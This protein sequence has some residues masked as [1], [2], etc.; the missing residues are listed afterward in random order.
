MVESLKVLSKLKMEEQPRCK[1]KVNFNFSDEVKIKNII[2]WFRWNFSILSKEKKVLNTDTVKLRLPTN[3]VCEVG[4]NIRSHWKE[5]LDLIKNHYN[6]V[7]YIVSHHSY[8]GTV[9]NYL[10]KENKC[11]QHRLYRNHCIQCEDDGIK[12]YVKDLDTLNKYYNW[13]SFNR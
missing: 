13:C 12:F 3:K 11:F 5:V 10:D 1:Q 6:I 4:L 2:I 9:L 8:S 7:A